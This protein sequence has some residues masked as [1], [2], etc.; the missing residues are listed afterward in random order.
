MRV[1]GNLNTIVFAAV[2]GLACSLLLVGASQ[3]TAPYRAAN[4][5]A[6]RVRNFLGALEVPVDPKSASKNLLEIFRRDV[7]VKKRGALE[8][9]EYIPERSC[10]QDLINI[11]EEYSAFKGI[12]KYQ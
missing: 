9:Y 1:K 4:E 11:C 10:V 7:Q 6:E 3:F 8:F 12:Q 5:E 2:L